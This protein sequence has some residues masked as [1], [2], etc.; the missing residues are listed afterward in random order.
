MKTN[1]LLF[2]A[3]ILLSTLGFVSCNLDTEDFDQ[4]KITHRTQNFEFTIH[5]LTNK[6]TENVLFEEYV[7]VD[8]QSVLNEY[9]NYSVIDFTEIDEIEF[10]VEEGQD[11]NLDF[12]ESASITVATT[13]DFADAVVVASID[14]IPEGATSINIPL[15]DEDYMAIVSDGGFYVRVE[16][17]YDAEL[18][19]EEVEA[20]INFLLALVLDID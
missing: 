3:L 13:E 15:S 6:D 18:P 4:L 14:D 17:S 2:F 11:Y 7:D 20:Y 1:R 10:G 12:M 9:G 5:D 8:L 16:A 19:A